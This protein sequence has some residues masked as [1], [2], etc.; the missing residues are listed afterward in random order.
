MSRVVATNRLQLRQKAASSV[1][2]SA[3]HV[4]LEPD[5]NGGGVVEVVLSTVSTFLYLAGHIEIFNCNYNC[6]HAGRLTPV[7]NLIRVQD[8]K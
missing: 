1:I 2:V 4:V 6:L 8:R 7:T 5:E 3:P